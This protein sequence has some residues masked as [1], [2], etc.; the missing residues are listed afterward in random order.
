MSGDDDDQRDRGGQ[1]GH[2]AE[3]Q[4]VVD[5]GEEICGGEEVTDILA[6]LEAAGVEGMDAGDEKAILADD[7]IGCEDASHLFVGLE[8]NYEQEP[9]LHL[10][11]YGSETFEPPDDYDVCVCGGGARR[12][13]DVGDDVG[14]IRK[15]VVGKKLLGASGLV[16]GLDVSARLPRRT[17]LSDLVD[18]RCSY[19]YFDQ[20]TADRR[21]LKAC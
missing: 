13:V 9:P 16:A 11:D 14:D 2:T 10:G 21:N 8:N 12:S 5:D 18:R 15:Y 19:S 17:F 7:E 1:N 4:I 6:G 20:E 3:A